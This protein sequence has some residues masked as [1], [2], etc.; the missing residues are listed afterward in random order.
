MGGFLPSRCP[1]CYDGAGRCLLMVRRTH[2]PAHSRHPVRTEAEDFAH[3]LRSGNRVADDVCSHVSI[4]WALL[5]AVGHPASRHDRQPEN[6]QRRVRTTSS[7]IS[8]H[9]RG[10]NIMAFQG[11]LESSTGY[12]LAGCAPAVGT[13][14]MVWTIREGTVGLRWRC[15][16]RRQLRP[17][18]HWCLSSPTCSVVLDPVFNTVMTYA[19]RRIVEDLVWETTFFCTVRADARGQKRTMNGPCPENWTAYAG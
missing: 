9:I 4:I 19:I 3:F 11:G 17:R 7:R 14:P 10:H 5:P 13:R 16:M 1:G 2:D 6:P 8:L 15:P 18:A 12:S